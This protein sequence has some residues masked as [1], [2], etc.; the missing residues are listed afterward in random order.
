MC[1]AFK[2]KKQFPKEEKVEKSASNGGAEVKMHVPCIV[3]VG[4][5]GRN[6][7]YVG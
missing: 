6:Y 3:R 5:G 7:W 2:G 4:T 1:S